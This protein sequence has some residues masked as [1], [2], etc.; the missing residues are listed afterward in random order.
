MRVVHVASEGNAEP[1]GKVTKWDELNAAGRNAAGLSPNTGTG[2][3]AGKAESGLAAKA[4]P[5]IATKTAR[6]A[7]AHVSSRAFNILI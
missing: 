3:T 1:G 6:T 2:V 7:A 5:V 4:A